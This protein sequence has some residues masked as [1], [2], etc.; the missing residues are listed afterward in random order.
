MPLLGEV[1]MHKTIPYEKRIL[2]KFEEVLLKYNHPRYLIDSIINANKNRHRTIKD[3][4]ESLGS[5]LVFQI[6]NDCGYKKENFL[7]VNSISGAENI[8]SLKYW[9]DDVHTILQLTRKY[10]ETK[11]S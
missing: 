7:F 11:K 9:I 2:T 1:H 4:T 3:L 8:D 5:M 10:D 6:F